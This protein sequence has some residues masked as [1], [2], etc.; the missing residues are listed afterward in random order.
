MHV[1]VSADGS[2]LRVPIHLIVFACSLISLLLTLLHY[3]GLALLCTL[4]DLIVL[5]GIAC[6]PDIFVL[7]I[8]V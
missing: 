1:T 4:L 5:H 3:S 2:I 7:V 6:N 8:I